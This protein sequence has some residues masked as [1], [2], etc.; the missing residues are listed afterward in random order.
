MARLREVAAAVFAGSDPMNQHRQILDDTKGSVS[1]C[2]ISLPR[3][4]GGMKPNQP[5]FTVPAGGC[6]EVC[7]HSRDHVLDH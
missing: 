6:P 4:T 3:F 7:S 5:N 2:S 1:T